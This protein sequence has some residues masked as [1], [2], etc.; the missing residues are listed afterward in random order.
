MRLVRLPFVSSAV[1]QLHKS[2]S[3]KMGMGQFSVLDLGIVFEYG[4][5]SYSLLPDTIF[6]VTFISQ[7]VYG[8]NFNQFGVT[9]PIL[10][11]S[12]K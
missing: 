10:R 8:S 2:N 1:Q 4:H 11:N 3:E 9:V 12:A 7:A 6:L 5:K